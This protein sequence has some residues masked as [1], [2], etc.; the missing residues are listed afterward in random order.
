MLKSQLFIIITI[1]YNWASRSVAVYTARHLASLIFVFVYFKV[2]PNLKY[3]VLNYLYTIILC[4][5][6][7]MKIINCFIL[8]SLFII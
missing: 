8:Y 6:K 5:I 3:N 4:T 2:D 1:Y 7:Y